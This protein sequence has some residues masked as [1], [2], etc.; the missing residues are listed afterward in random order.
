MNIHVFVC[1][2]MPWY[3]C[4]GQRTIF[5]SPLLPPSGS[6]YGIK[7]TRLG[8]KGSYLLSHLTDP[9]FSSLG[10]KMFVSRSL[11]LLF[12]TSRVSASFIFSPSTPCPTP[13]WP[14]IWDAS[15]I[16]SLKNAGTMSHHAQIFI[17]NPPFSCM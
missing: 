13:C 9:R 7:V 11:P 10:L 14:L 16:L 6:W 2:S 5:G 1:S 8:G 4:G 12:F 17:F 15:P 3:S